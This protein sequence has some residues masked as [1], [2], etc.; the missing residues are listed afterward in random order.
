MDVVGG[1]MEYVNKGVGSLFVWILDRLYG[2]RGNRRVGE[3][4]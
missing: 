3:D 4:R 2:W 1:Y